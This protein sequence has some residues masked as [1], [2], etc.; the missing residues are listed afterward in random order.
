MRGTLFQLLV[1]FVTSWTGVRGGSG[2]RRLRG[3]QSD[4]YDRSKLHAAGFGRS[5]FNHRQTPAVAGIYRGEY[6]I[7][8]F[9]YFFKSDKGTLAIVVSDASLARMTLGKAVAMIGT[10][11]SGK[12]GKRRQINATATPVGANHGILKLCFVAGRRK[13][14]FE[15]SYHFV[16]NARSRRRLNSHEKNYCSARRRPHDRARGISQDA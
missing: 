1:L 5:H 15:P 2:T 14:T 8:V 12:Y 10:A 4:G 3:E 6:K 13:M 11:T 16:N 7:N 9:P